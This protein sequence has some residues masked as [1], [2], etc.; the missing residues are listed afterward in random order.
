M[1]NKSNK[2]ASIDGIGSIPGGEYDVVSVDGIGKIKGKVICN[3]LKA[4]G[5]LKILIVA[6]VLAVKV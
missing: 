2:N 3:E 6:E 4:D 1:M 5:L